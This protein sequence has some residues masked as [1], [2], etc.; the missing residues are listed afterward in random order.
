MLGMA[1]C[2]GML[3]YTRT[4]AEKKKTRGDRRKG[5]TERTDAALQHNFGMRH[6][7][8]NDQN[9]MHCSEC[10]RGFQIMSWRTTNR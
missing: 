3:R 10:W 4:L 9:L 5:E 2:R 8:N 6:H 1:R 7:K